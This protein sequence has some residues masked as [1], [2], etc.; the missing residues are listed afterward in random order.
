MAARRMMMSDARIDLAKARLW[1]AL[2]LTRLGHSS[3]PPVSSFSPSSEKRV[4][5]RNSAENRDCSGAGDRPP[6]DPGIGI[7]GAGDGPGY[8]HAGPVCCG[9]GLASVSTCSLNGRKS[10]SRLARTAQPAGAGPSAERSSE[11]RY[12]FS[13]CASDPCSL[14]GRASATSNGRPYAPV[15]EFVPPPKKRIIG[16]GRPKG[17]E[18]CPLPHPGDAPPFGSSSP[19][20]F[21]IQSS[22]SV[23]WPPL[24]MCR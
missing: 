11:S 10:G 14:G 1:M 21:L 15:A 2:P 7:R 18:Q 16:S 6:G 24:E 9:A 4:D 17:I 22:L 8:V 5:D 20:F 19:F 13:I 12:K 23:H 3:R